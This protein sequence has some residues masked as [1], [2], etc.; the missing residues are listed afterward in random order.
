MVINVKNT[1]IYGSRLN[2]T[3]TA[4][5]DTDYL[6]VIANDS[7]QEITDAAWPKSSSGILKFNDSRLPDFKYDSCVIHN[8][9]FN[10][11]FD[12]SSIKTSIAFVTEK[13]FIAMIKMN[14]VWVLE[15]LFADDK[16]KLNPESYKEYFKL[17]IKNLP[18]TTLYEAY[19]ALNKAKSLYRNGNIRKANK[20][21]YYAHKF[22]N[23]MVQLLTWNKICCLSEA[24]E[25]FHKNYDTYEAGEK[26]FK[27]YLDSIKKLYSHELFQNTRDAVVRV[28]PDWLDFTSIDLKNYKTDQL[29]TLPSSIK[30]SFIIVHGKTIS[31]ESESALK[32]SELFSHGL[33]SYRY[34]EIMV[35]NK[36]IICALNNRKAGP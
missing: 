27:T 32:K 20:N 11:L 14:I 25:L 9:N 1:Y 24:V 36:G 10:I 15:L 28:I 35:F 4:E 18:G 12:N 29:I 8:G 6:Y 33:R 5:S 21:I 26:S 7:L 17:N 3:A 13:H 31:L 22:L 16:F 34:L 2:G 19:F 23:Y 30:T